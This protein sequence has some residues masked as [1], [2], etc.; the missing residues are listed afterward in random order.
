MLD[1]LAPDPR[2]SSLQRDWTY[3][4]TPAGARI[5]A[6]RL[7]HR[8]RHREPPPETAVLRAPSGAARPWTIYFAFTPTG[9][10]DPVHRET[11]DRLRA[12]GRPILTVCAAPGARDVPEDIARRSDALVWKALPGFDFSAYSAGLWLLARCCPGSDALVLNDSLFGPLTDLRPWL[13]AMRWDLTAFT[14]SANVENHIQS[15]AFHLRGVT[16]ERMRALA[17]V[18][19]TGFAYQ[20]FWAVVFMQETRFARIA[21]RQMS[22]GSL[23]YA[24]DRTADPLLDLALPLVESGFPFLKRSLLGKFDHLYPADAIRATLHASG[25]PL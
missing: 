11:L 23:L 25:Y 22:V 18:L 21:A 12:L 15:Y 6:S 2:L 10:A 20:V 24:P 9:Q 14:A 16:P 19:P 17:P 5:G 7:L 13:A 1:L 3:T 4:P 8:V